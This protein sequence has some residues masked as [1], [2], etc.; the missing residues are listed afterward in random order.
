M[1]TGVL[2]TKHRPNVQQY[3]SAVL[4][5]PSLPRPPPY[6]SVVS[7]QLTSAVLLK[8][9]QRGTQIEA[10]PRGAFSPLTEQ[11]LPT[12]GDIVGIDAEFVTLNMVSVC[13]AEGVVA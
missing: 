13:V 4:Y 6:P 8:D 10:Q 2:S 12:K 5:S 3:K 7:S 9:S 11:E 1:C